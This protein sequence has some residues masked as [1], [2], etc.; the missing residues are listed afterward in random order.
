MSNKLIIVFALC[1]CT[2]A[3]GQTQRIK[4]SRVNLLEKQNKPAA[5]IPSILLKAYSQG[6]IK[7]YYPKSLKQEVSL[8]Q[9]LNHFGMKSK[10]EKVLTTRQPF[11]FCV[12]APS[13]EIDSRVMDCMKYSFEIGE[14]IFRNNITY[15]QDKRLIYV[16]VIYSKKCSADGIEKE[17]PV[18]KMGDIKKLYEKEH[19]IINPQNSAVSYTIADYLSL[20][21]VRSVPYK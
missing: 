11:W 12:D 15:Q 3:L 9:F 4:K 19:K 18:F 1:V 2:S 21:L 5:S 10:A 7:A 13:I 16:K 17:G 6:E 20:K 8:T 14:E